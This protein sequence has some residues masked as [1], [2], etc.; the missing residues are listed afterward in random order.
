MS[1]KLSITGCAGEDVIS[2]PTG[3]YR[4]DQISSAFQTQ[5]RNISQQMHEILKGQK[6][7]IY[8]NIYQDGLNC[9]VLSAN[10]SGWRKGKAIVKFELEFIPDEIEEDQEGEASA[11]VDSSLD[12]FSRSQTHVD[13]G[14]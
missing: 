7:E 13:I 2:F 10:S 4:A 1:Q 12:S 8:P 3:M 11:S 9:E 5:L 6:I 14:R